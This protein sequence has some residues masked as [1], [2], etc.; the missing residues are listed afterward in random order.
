MKTDATHLKT[1]KYLQFYCFNMY[2]KGDEQDNKI[3]K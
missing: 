2:F 3:I 1:T